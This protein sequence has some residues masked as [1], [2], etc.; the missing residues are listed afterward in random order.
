MPYI[1][2]MDEIP[3]RLYYQDLGQGQPVIFIHGW[4]SSHEMWEYQL[5]TLPEHYRCIAYDRRGFG[6]SDKPWTGYDYDTFASDL[7]CLIDQLDLTDVTLVGFSMGGGE[8]V[9]YLSAYGSERISK[10]VLVSAVTPFMLRTDDNEDGLPKKMFDKMVQKIKNDRPKFLAGFGKDFFGVSKTEKPVS[11]ELLQWAHGLTLTAT[12]KS[13][14]D[15]VRAFSETDFRK[16]CAAIDVPTLLIHG[17]EDKT[18]PIDIS[19]YKTAD[20][21]KDAQ[22]IVYEGG[23]H[24]I[25]VTEKDR[26]NQD[27]VNFIDS[28][29]EKTEAETTE[30]TQMN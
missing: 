20:L 19:A 8:V 26:L 28:K 9:R 14:I 1:Q 18:V 13:T 5:G 7:K 6:K 16:D 10:A 30:A 22:L 24:G 21:I 29:T 23:P 15:C 12:Q 3:V 27:L 25:F 17:D 2:T 4:P 11:E